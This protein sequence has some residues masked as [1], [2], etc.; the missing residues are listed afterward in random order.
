MNNSVQ[1]EH[2]VV[3]NESATTPNT[4][5]NNNDAPSSEPKSVG[6]YVPPHLRGHNSKP[7][8][9]LKSDKYEETIVQ[10]HGDDVP[11]PIQ[12][13]ED[14]NLG[15]VLPNIAMYDTPTPIQKHAMPIILEGR[16]LV[17]LAQTGNFVFGL[18]RKFSFSL[19]LRFFLLKL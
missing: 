3:D 8:V 10:T 13:Y 17:A 6:R 14:L 12:R 1:Y 19:I 9:A 11:A 18:V 5:Y 7:Y 15:S 16:D 2:G 4:S